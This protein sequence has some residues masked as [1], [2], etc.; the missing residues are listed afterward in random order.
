[1]RH[2]RELARGHPDAD[3]GPAGAQWDIPGYKTRNGVSPDG[4]R[5][6]VVS[7]NTDSL[8]PE[9]GVPA[10]TTDPVSEIVENALCGDGR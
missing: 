10:P 3:H 2:H 4:E 8:V 9:P 5:S 1:M 7:I 6:V